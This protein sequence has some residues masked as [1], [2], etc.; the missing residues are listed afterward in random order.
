M[1]TFIYLIF[2]KKSTKYFVLAIL[3]VAAALFVSWINNLRNDEQYIHEKVQNTLLELD[4]KMDKTLSMLSDSVTQ[5][6]SF[7]ELKSILNEKNIHAFGF[8]FYVFNK[9]T[10]IFWS[11]NQVPVFDYYFENEFSEPFRNIANGW[12]EVRKKTI[13]DYHLIGL[14]RIKSAY[15]YQN[16]HLQN[17]FNPQLTIPGNTQISNEQ[18]RH[19]IS[20]DDG[21]F[22]FSIEFD[23]KA[24]LTKVSLS[25]ITLFYFMAYILFIV[26]LYTAY[27]TF[28]LNSRYRIILLL[29]FIVDLFIFRFLLFFFQVPGVLYSSPLF[30]PEILAIS[31]LSPS[32]GD[33]LA[34]L[35]L[36]FAVSFAIHQ[37]IQTDS[38]NISRNRILFY[39]LFLLFINYFLFRILTHT[40]EAIVINSNVSFNLN[41]INLIDI[42]SVLGFL[43]MGLAIF[44]YFFLTFKSNL[45]LAE[46]HQKH[47]SYIITVVPLLIILFLIGYFTE[48][49]IL[50]FFIFSLYI[51][52]FRIILSSRSVGIRF[53][54]TLY[55]IFLFSILTTIVL[56]HSNRIREREY[57]ELFARQLAEQRDPVAEFSFKRAVDEIKSDSV[58]MVLYDTYQFLSEEE[59]ENI[60]N[61]I[62]N[63]HLSAFQGKFEILL[64]ICDSSKTLNLQPDDYTVDCFE[65]F[66]NLK[67]EYGQPTE[68]ENLYFIDYEFADD[69]YLG[70][71]DI[72]SGAAPLH[73]YVELFPLDLP[74]GIGYPELLIDQEKND[75]VNWSEYSFARYENGELIY[76]YGKYYYSINLSKYDTEKGNSWFFD[77]NGFNHLIIKMSGGSA[78]ILSSENP[79]FL[80]IAAPFSY[81]SIFFGVLVFILFLFIKSPVH[82]K[83]RRMGLK[84]RIQ[85]SITVLI[86]LSFLFVGTASLFYIISLNNNK[87]YT[88]L[89]EKAHSTL[90][91]LEHKLADEEKLDRDMERYLTDLLYKFSLVFFTD[92]NLYDLDGTLLA[93]SRP[94]IFNRGLISAK[95]NPF[96]YSELKVYQKSLLI[97]R[98][99]IGDYEYL[100]AYIPFRNIDNKVIA[101]LNLPYFARQDELTNEI[102]T[103]LVA[104][105][106]IYVILIALA[107]FTILIISNYIT[108]PVQ[109]LKEKIGKLKL[110]KTDEKIAWE[111]D[112][113]IGSLVREYNRKV[114]ELAQSAILLAKSERESA[115]REMARQI[116]HEIKNPLTPMKLSVQYLQKA[117]D[118]KAP[119]WEQRLKRFSRTIIEQIDSLSIIASEFSDFAKMPRS[120]FQ[121]VDLDEIINRSITLY[122]DTT[123]VT[124]EY[125]S[126]KAFVWADK[127]QL[128]RVFNNLIKNSI[129]AMPDPHKGIIRVET[130]T[131]DHEH[132]VTFKDNGIGIS[133][134]QQP[135]IFYPNFTTKSSGMG[136]GLAMV[137]SIIE[138]AKG[139]IS[140][141]S[142]VGVGTTFIIRLPAWTE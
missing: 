104:Y 111:K 101:Y 79:D 123:E 28:R 130:E 37:A 99:Q 97:H 96:A 67:N 81:I 27:Q 13:P 29:A 26:W 33:L 132:I 116:A 102:A 11:D 56:H 10:L 62:R 25:L 50:S 136:L 113:E 24:G 92:L 139:N 5:V 44:V 109:M 121:V 106:N 77:L 76:R 34:N 57:R 117:W 18:G 19:N 141:E 91:E 127:E 64:T 87:N 51:L 138:N 63:Q 16:E 7:A 85:L 35:L 86:V 98:E 55:F 124:F 133:E 36:M 20:N 31:T 59:L 74:K 108:K 72:S 39:S 134:E 21:E 38:K 131:T 142:Q 9:D 68:T 128:L 54:S 3:F 119:D 12:Y 84:S 70:S 48:Q 105:I 58:L 60:E 78:I 30:S 23:E 90:I 94:E 49:S 17:Q 40:L 137:K 80:K 135:R 112:D 75:P 89:S 4:K 118:D 126:T 73:I 95:M 114:E 32:L 15:P 65:Y 82:L 103:F 43:C 42:Y 110:G 140:F 107:I 66:E 129:Q 52:S 6:S 1:K 122:K 120:K 14:I 45:F 46:I 47:K 2:N 53:T 125:S 41:Y 22:L 83:I 8:S 93:T 100:S 115:W 71:I 61:Y 88:I 69:N